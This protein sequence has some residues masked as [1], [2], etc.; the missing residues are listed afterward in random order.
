MGESGDVNVVALAGVRHVGHQVV[1]GF[2]GIEIRRE[3][4][5]VAARCDFD[6]F[7]RGMTTFS[8]MWPTTSS[9]MTKTGQSI[10]LG[11]VERLDGEV[12]TFLRR[13]GAE[14]DDLVIAVRSPAHL[15][16]VGLRRERGQ[17]GR[18]AAALHINEDARRL[19]HERRSRCAPS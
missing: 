19:G 10:L 15:H 6:L 1:L 8:V 7:G 3:E 17:S 13:V 4:R 5:G 2:V 9:I 12:E 11:V 14:R 18:R 16:H